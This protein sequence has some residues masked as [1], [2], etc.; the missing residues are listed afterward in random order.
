MHKGD[1]RPLSWPGVMQDI[2]ELRSLAREAGETW[3]PWERRRLMMAVHHRL[4][5]LNMDIGA[6]NR[7]HAAE[8]PDCT[9][10]GVIEVKH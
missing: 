5:R 3:I 4:Q 7:Q 2:S 1:G 6:L 10:N 8:H 9:P